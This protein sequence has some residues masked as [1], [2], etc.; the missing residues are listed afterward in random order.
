MHKGCFTDMFSINA[1]T[2]MQI[3]TARRKTFAKAC[4]TLHAS[5]MP[6][7]FL[8]EQTD[9]CRYREISSSKALQCAGTQQVRT[10]KRMLQLA[11][12]AIV[13]HGR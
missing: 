12:D 11:S 1:Q 7:H 3:H 13:V 4:G 10:E 9:W 6:N 2:S 5:E 8:Q